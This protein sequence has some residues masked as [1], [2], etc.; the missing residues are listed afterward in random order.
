METIKSNIQQFIAG[1]FAGWAAV[2]VSQPLDYLKTQL[3]VNY[4]VPSIRKMFADI[5]LLG[6]YKGASSVYLSVGIITFLEY[7]IF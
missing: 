2:S 5:G 3:Q 4:R 6:F 1:N 7:T